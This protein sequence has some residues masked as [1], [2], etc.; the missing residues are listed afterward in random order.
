MDLSFNSVTKRFPIPGAGVNGRLLTVV[1]SL[2]L[3]VR[4]GEHAAILGRSG[5]G[6]TTLLKLAAGLLTPDEGE[7]LLN[8]IRADQFQEPVAFAF[9]DPSLLPWLTVRENIAVPSKVLSN[10]RRK[11]AGNPEYWIERVGLIGAELRY[12]HEL[13]GGMQSRCS[14]ARCLSIPSQLVLMDEPLGNLDA[15]TRV[16]LQGELRDILQREKRTLLFVTHNVEEAVYM[17]DRLLVFRNK[18]GGN[19]RTDY[20]DLATTSREFDGDP[21]LIGHDPRYG[22]LI[23]EIHE[24]LTR[25]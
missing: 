16:E 17:C 23:Q 25:R 11:S 18:C 10:K 14:I 20:M 12:P 8:G 7:V 13:S 21:G 24:F 2:T 15:V 4:E 6:K 5:C 3:S 9:Q 19:P 1:D 22:T